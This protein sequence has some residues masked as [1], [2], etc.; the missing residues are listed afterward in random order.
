M[1]VVYLLVTKDVRQVQRKVLNF[2]WGYGCHWLRQTVVMTPLAK[3]GLGLIP[4]GSRLKSMYVKHC[5]LRLGGERGVRVRDVMEDVRRWWGGRDLEECMSM[6]RYLLQVRNPENVMACVLGRLVRCQEVLEGETVFPLYNW[7][8]IW[9]DFSK[10]RVKSRVRETMYRFLHG[11]LPTKVR[12]YQM[13]ILQS[14]CCVL[15]VW[16]EE[17]AYHVVYFCEHIERA[18]LW[19]R[20]VGYGGLE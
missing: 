3:G 16:G 14:Q 19:F 10:L 4:L 9:G 6:L 12:L 8:R 18:R 11:I 7:T 5:Y 2:I 1:A 17:T 13:G 15:C 20:S